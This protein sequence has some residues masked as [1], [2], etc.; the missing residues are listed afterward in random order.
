[1]ATNAERSERVRPM[2]TQYASLGA[3][4]EVVP[5]AGEV[6]D[7]ITDMLHFLRTLPRTEFESSWDDD[8]SGC[9]ECHAGP[10]Q[11]CLAV[12]EALIERAF[13]NFVAEIEE[14]N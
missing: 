12:Y 9:E 4:T 13:N 6:Q 14:D 11:P 8:N 2:I 1:M 7:M 5:D 10:G 3:D